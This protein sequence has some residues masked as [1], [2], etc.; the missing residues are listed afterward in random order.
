[1]L[2]TQTPSKSKLT[3]FKSVFDHD[4]A[5]FW[6]QRLNPIWS[7]HQALGKIIDKTTTADGMVSLLLRTNRHF[8]MGEAGQHHPV[9]VELK[10]RRYERTY[11]LTQMGSHQVLLTVKKVA[12][13]VV[14]T[15]LVDHAQ[16][17]DI[18][19]FGQPFGDLCLAEAQSN[20]VLLAAGSGI[21]PMYSLLEQW[22]KQQST[23]QPDSNAT[24]PQH[25]S[26]SQNIQLLYWVKQPQDVAFLPRLQKLAKTYPN[27]Q[28]QI[29]YT[30]AEQPDARLNAAHLELLDPTQHN[31]RSIYVCG[32]A[33]FVATASSVFADFA[34]VKTEAFSLA[35][36]SSDATGQVNVTLTQS[37]TTVSIPRGQS[38]LEGL[39]QQGIRPIYGCRMGVCNKCACPKSQGATKNLVNGSENTE[40]GQFLKLCVNSAQSDLI[41]DL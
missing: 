36:I 37:K 9:L 10:G 14:S 13:G 22:A 7:T 30:Q 41:I 38:I 34:D 29:F 15:W 24:S 27:F 1:M 31:N 35:P 25:S 23:K 28:Y 18:I 20:L 40:P 8:Q 21:T 19:E 26:D 4:T 39:E 3:L 2:A 17:G 5:N 33:G 6:L 11:S 32:P 16:I 12:Q